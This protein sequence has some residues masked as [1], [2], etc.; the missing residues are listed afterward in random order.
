[1]RRV[2]LQEVEDEAPERLGRSSCGRVAGAVD[3]GEARAGDPGG[4]PLGARRGR[5]ASSAP[6]MT[7]VGAR[8]RGEAVVERLHRALAGA[9]QA[10]GEPRRVGCARRSARIRSRRAP[11]AAGA[12][13][14][15]SGARSHSSTNAVDAVA[16]EAA[17]QRLVR[18]PARGARSDASAMPADGLSSTSRRRCPGGRRRAGARRA[19][20]ASSRRR[21][22]AR[23]RARRGSP[24]GRPR[25]ARRG[26]GAGRSESRAAVARAGRRR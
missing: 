16:L 21:R 12:G 17:R 24:P 15:T 18:G 5:S 1:M 23:R 2:L 8:D 20:R 25:R 13:S 14:R 22:R 10:G 9:A 6:A 3:D 19:P 11:A 7:S 26:V 4:D